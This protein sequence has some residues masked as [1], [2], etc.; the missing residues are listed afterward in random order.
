MKIHRKGRKGNALRAAT[1]IGNE[2]DH[3]GPTAQKPNLVFND[4][5][6]TNSRNENLQ[7]AG[8]IPM[9]HAMHGTFWRAGVWPASRKLFAGERWCFL[10]M[11]AEN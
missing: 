6:R 5:R 3:K 10:T 1:A 8:K 4:E 9:P 2:L 11:K 7:S